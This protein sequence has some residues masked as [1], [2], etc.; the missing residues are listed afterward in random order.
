MKRRLIA[1]AGAL[2]SIGFLAASAVANYLFGASLGRTSWEAQ[3]YG[4]VGVLAVGM[5][6]LAPFYIPGS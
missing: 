3:L 1:A 2:V 4:A 6:A 5:N